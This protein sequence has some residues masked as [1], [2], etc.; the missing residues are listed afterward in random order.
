[1][2]QFDL[3][4]EMEA[5][6][7]V[8][9]IHV[10]PAIRQPPAIVMANAIPAEEYPLGLKPLVV[11]YADWLEVKITDAEFDAERAMAPAGASDEYVMLGMLIA[12]GVRARPSTNLRLDYLYTHVA[13]PFNIRRRTVPGYTIICHQGPAA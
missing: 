6:A 10:L 11:I 13:G 2:S 1:M 4:A 9:P 7:P 12:R 3:F 5:P 8:A